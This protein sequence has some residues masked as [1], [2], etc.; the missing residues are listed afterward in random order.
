ME[1]IKDTLFNNNKI[2]RAW[3]V[4]VRDIFLSSPPPPTRPGNMCRV[5]YVI[6]YIFFFFVKKMLRIF[7]E[8]DNFGSNFSQKEKI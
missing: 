2:P 4:E 7:N 8:Q 3:Y 5:R 6:L 1:T